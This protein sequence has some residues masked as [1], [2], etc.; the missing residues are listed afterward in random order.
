MLNSKEIVWL[1]SYHNKVKKNLIKFM[2]GTEK[3]DLINACSPI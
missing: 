3:T 2:N 1:N